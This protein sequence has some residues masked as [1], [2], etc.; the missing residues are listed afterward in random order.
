[1]RSIFLRVTAAIGLAVLFAAC[2]PAATQQQGKTTDPGG[3]SSVGAPSGDALAE[4][5]RAVK[6][7]NDG[8]LDEATIESIHSLLWR[9]KDDHG[10]TQVIV[11][12]DKELASQAD[13][14]VRI[15]RGRIVA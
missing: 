4:H 9:L 6:L 5:D 13:R 10:V 2:G 12:H 7:K 3:G 11:T 15:E 14:V 1:M 8:N